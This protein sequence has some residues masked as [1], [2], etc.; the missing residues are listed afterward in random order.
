MTNGN[1]IG[2]KVAMILISIILGLGTNWTRTVSADVE[3]QKEHT[4]AAEEN[5]R[6][7]HYEAQIQRG[8]LETI[9]ANTGGGCENVADV[10]PLREAK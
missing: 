2:W 9:C 10:R 8:L 3:K 5:I 7:I 6:T 4:S 1:G